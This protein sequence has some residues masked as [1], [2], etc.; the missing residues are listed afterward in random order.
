MVPKDW[1]LQTAERWL[2][3]LSDL[4][5]Y[6]D[7]MT[8]LYSYWPFWA[9][10][11]SYVEQDGQ[12]WSFLEP[13]QLGIFSERSWGLWPKGMWRARRLWPLPSAVSFNLPEIE[14]T[15]GCWIQG[16]WLLG[17]CSGS[18]SSGAP[19]EAPTAASMPVSFHLLGYVPRGLQPAWEERHCWTKRKARAPEEPSCNAERAADKACP[20]SSREEI[21]G[22]PRK[23]IHGRGTLNA[24]RVNEKTLWKEPWL[25]SSGGSRG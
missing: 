24:V 9:S 25:R 6:K 8:L 1:R 20:D 10:V 14:L 2:G 15:G 4:S 21:K 12:S 13:A 22:S 23:G 19:G 18:A 11:Q 16:L 3:K 7:D 5:I 17:S